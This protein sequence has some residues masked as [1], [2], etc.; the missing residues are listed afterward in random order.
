M[1]ARS[2]VAH[3]LTRTCAAPLHMCSFVR[4]LPH[5]FSQNP[6]QEG[7]FEGSRP[8]RVDT[9]NV[10]ALFGVPPKSASE[11]NIWRKILMAP[12]SIFSDWLDS[13]RHT[14]VQRSRFSCER[15]RDFRKKGEQ[16]TPRMGFFRKNS[17]NVPIF[18][19]K[20]VFSGPFWPFFVKSRTRLC[21]SVFFCA[22]ILP[23][24]RK[25][26][27]LSSSARSSSA[28]VLATFVDRI[29]LNWVFGGSGHPHSR[30]RPHP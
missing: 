8:T 29:F 6:C 16:R 15:V 18:W 19:S 21:S 2:T 4:S 3:S 30:A 28:E 24:F 26:C 20:S 14:T 1:C 27:P 12:P 23:K 11:P 10:T 7:P 17:G 22:Q 25:S 5:G 13:R 9:R